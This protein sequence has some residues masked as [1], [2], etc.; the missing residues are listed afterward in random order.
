[1]L[2]NLRY[3]RS[4]GKG[5]FARVID[6]KL[7]RAR[8][9]RRTCIEKEHPSITVGRRGMTKLSFGLQGRFMLNWFALN[10]KPQFSNIPM[11]IKYIVGITLT[12]VALAGCSTE[13]RES[14]KEA[15]EAKLMAEAKVSKADAQATASAQVPN[16]TVKEAE[17]EKEHGKLIWSFDISTPGTA[18]ITEVNVDAMTGQVV[19]TEKEKA[20]DEAKEAKKE[21]D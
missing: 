20:E 2:A 17:L 5:N 16:G 11:N 7:P 13:S 8:A 4:K 12:A 9:S 1:V 3:Y 19:S 10:P 21:K 18:D 15:K 14:R 6:H